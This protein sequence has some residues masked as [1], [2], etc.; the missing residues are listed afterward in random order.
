MAS[1]VARSLMP[2]LFLCGFLNER[3]LK[4]DLQVIIKLKIGIGKT[5][6][7]IGSKVTK[8]VFDSVKK[9]HSTVPYQDVIT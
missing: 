8:A 9:V 2:R 4:D 1:L 5:I 7:N 6:T 3:V